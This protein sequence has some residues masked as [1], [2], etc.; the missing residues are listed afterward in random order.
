MVRGHLL[1]LCV[2]AGSSAR[3]SNLAVIPVYGRSS[4]SSTREG[5][6]VSKWQQQNLNL[7]LSL[8][9]SKTRIMFLQ[10]K[11]KEPGKVHGPW[12]PLGRDWFHHFHVSSQIL[13]SK[14]Q[15]GSDHHM[16]YP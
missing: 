9:D 5:G 2:C 1:A 8:S 6:T 13:E 11:K 16:T 14:C 7:N 3:H 12:R 4:S 15:M 10:W